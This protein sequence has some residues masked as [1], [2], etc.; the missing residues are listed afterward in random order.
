MTRPKDPS[1]DRPR[2][3][4][5]QTVADLAGVSRSAVSRAF[6]PGAYLGDEKRQ[7][8]LRVAAEAG[9]QPNALAAGLKGGQS[10]LVAVFVGNTRSPYDMD[11]LSR[12]AGALNGLKK[13]P[14]VIDGSGDSAASAMDELLRYPLDAL[15]LRGG[16]MSAEIVTQCARFGI[17]MISSGRPV[18]SRG[19]DNVLCRNAEGTRMATDLLLSKGRERFGYIGGPKDF[20]S[21]HERQAGVMQ[22][23][24][25]FGLPLAAMAESDFTVESGYTAARHLFENHKLDAVICANDAS[26]IGA[27]AAAREMALDVPGDVSIIGFDDIAMAKWPTFNLT[28]VRNP[29]G[30]SVDEILGLLQRRLAD[31]SKPDETIHIDPILVERGTH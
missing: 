7:K 27:L 30:I 22:A 15:I 3:I 11:F 2:R 18:A 25:A 29:L 19:V 16:S 24:T 28:T 9:Y 10:N 14:I 8:I 6:T 4:T 26:A 17:P 21:S 5:A 13:W 20:Y 31:P 1:A 23:L 12:L